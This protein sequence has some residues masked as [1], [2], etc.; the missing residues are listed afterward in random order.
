MFAFDSGQRGKIIPSSLNSK[1]LMQARQQMREFLVDLE[2][3]RR[4]QTD[5]PP[6]WK[7]RFENDVSEALL[8]LSRSKCA[9][10]ETR[11]S[12]DL[13][14]PYRFRPPGYATP[15]TMPED[16]ICYL[17]LAFNWSNLFPICPDCR[18]DDPSFFPVGE[19][20]LFPD[21]ENMHLLINDPVWA[22]DSGEEALF[23]EPGSYNQILPEEIKT[24]I[25]G[26]WEKG[27]DRWQAT[28][29]QFKLN[30]DALVRQRGAVIKERIE[31]LRTG[32]V[33]RE[34][35]R[36]DWLFALEHSDTIWAFFCQI[37]DHFSPQMTQQAPRDAWKVVDYLE[38]ATTIPDYREHFDRAVNLLQFQS[39]AN[40]QNLSVAQ[41]IEPETVLSPIPEEDG[42]E[43][44][45]GEE[46]TLPIPR[47]LNHPFLKT[48][49]IKNYKS[50]EKIEF[51]LPSELHAHDQLRLQA[52]PTGEIPKAPCLLILGENA[53]GKSSILEAIVLACLPESIRDELAVKPHR[54][55][56]N[57][58]YMGEPR[59]KPRKTSTVEVDFHGSKPLKL[60]IS[61]SKNSITHTTASKADT[62]VMPLVFGYG[63]HR[64]YGGENGQKPIGRVETLF[65]NDR[66]MPDPQPWLIGLAH[67][68]PS[69]LHEVVAALRYIIEIDGEFRDIEVRK[70]P[71][72]GEERCVINI[73]KTRID[74]DEKL[75]DSKKSYVL[76][77]RLDVVSSGYRAV[78]ALVCDVLA[79]LMEHNATSAR[80]ARMSRAIVLIDEIE[81]HLH[82][83]WKMQII[84]GLRRAL[85]NVTFILTTHDPLCIRGM[86]QDEV[87]VL[88]RYQSATGNSGS[89]LP[90]V[91]E[92]VTD[93]GNIEA[94]TIEQLLTSDLFQLFSTEAERTERD[95]AM[96]AD[97]YARQQAGED[98]A[99]EHKDLI[100]AF[101][102][103]IADA[104]PYGHVEITQVVQEALADYLAERA[105]SETNAEADAR[106]RAKEAVIEFLKELAP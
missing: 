49:S 94:L 102:A 52:N 65:R 59:K 78:L 10:C 84:S 3:E 92:K 47:D 28:V 96:V 24:T 20:R 105:K 43:E 86:M 12:P 76:P 71:S 82:P 38:S 74:A 33:L 2:P 87:M 14:Q 48:V 39:M 58:E 68:D 44:A 18:P 79:G 15:T 77:Q 51:D 62:R 8:S 101:N 4:M 37:A 75:P 27:S 25:N 29:A 61:T 17:W 64:L 19:S 16:R 45:G 70:D 34:A 40:E 99:E 98:L 85:P 81:A 41:A 6:V 100:K 55:T 66:E 106:Q 21:P 46:D 36:G 35:E 7:E 83:R 31:L 57:P 5:L 42:A 30:R 97:L 1:R 63:A 95:F 54:L 67:N 93:F 9:F 88:N 90:E 26:Y 80:D 22:F 32:L 104:L 11:V 103:Q 89:T 13:L 69:A 50:L 72:D 23:F 60:S 91:V 56:L 53:T 73:I